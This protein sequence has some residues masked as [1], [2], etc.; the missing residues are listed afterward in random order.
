MYF[1]QW[2]KAIYHKIV[3]EVE[4]EEGEERADTTKII[5]RRKERFNKVS[6]PACP[7]LC[8]QKDRQAEREGRGGGNTSRVKTGSGKK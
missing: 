4:V 5:Q 3:V 1:L 2:R 6:L 7:P 8:L